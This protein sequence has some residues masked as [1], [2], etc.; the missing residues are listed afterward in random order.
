MKRVQLEIILGTLFVFLSALILI[1]YATQETSRL[2][3]YEVA[4]EA[5]LIEFGASIYENNCT[6]CHGDFAQGIAGIAPCLRCEELFDG[7]IEAI[8]WEGELEDYIVSVVTTGRQVSTRAEYFGGGS[9]AM[10]TWSEKFGGPLRDDQVRAV[11]AY[12]MNFQAEALGEVAAVPPPPIAIDS[13][14]PE[15]LGRAQFVISGCTACHAVSGVSEATIGPS[16][17]GIATRAETRVEGLSAAE[18]I[19]ESIIDPNA[20]LVEGYGADIML[21]TFGESMA[22]EDFNNLIAYLLT[23][24]EE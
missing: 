20:Y 19:L 18:Y 7:R 22:E 13:S 21:Q 6:S 17:N 12:I 24:T 14:T 11:S 5:E 1:S 15:G 16:L 23:L 3:E 4:Q 9:P 10:P 8:G 2:A